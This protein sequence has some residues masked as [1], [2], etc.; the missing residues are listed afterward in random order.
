MQRPLETTIYDDIRH[1]R[2]LIHAH[3]EDSHT[4]VA[5]G[6]YRDSGKS[7]YLH[8]ENHL[9]QV[10]D[11]FD[12]PAQALVSFERFHGDTMR[13]GPAPMTDTE[14]AAAKAPTSLG[15]PTTEP[16]P[17]APAPEIV[18]AYAADAGDHDVILDA[19]L[20][21]H[22]DWEKSR[23]CSDDTTHAL[24]ESQTLRIER[25]HEAH[26]R[27]TAW[28]VAAYE[29]PVSDRMGHLTRPASPL[30]PCSKPCCT[31]SPR[32]TGGTPP[33]ALPWTR[34]ASPRPRSPS[35]KPGGSTP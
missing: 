27:E 17:P 29:T 1:G 10:A 24:H 30:P 21:A 9:R 19:F 2:L 7:V 26:P 23:T 33:S 3:A 31:T 12:S 18:S 32:T 25:V 5:V 20:A 22:A 14:R 11:T 6:T 16:E 35:P 13:P 34:R 8:G 15:T 28:T 4:T